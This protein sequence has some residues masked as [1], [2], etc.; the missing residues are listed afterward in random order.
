MEKTKSF[1]LL[2]WTK[3]PNTPMFLTLEGL[4]R[5]LEKNLGLKSVGFIMRDNNYANLKPDMDTDNYPYGYF[6]LTNFT[7]LVDRQANK[8]L[9]RHGSG[10]DLSNYSNATIDKDYTF[11]VELTFEFHFVTNNVVDMLNISE[12][13]AVISAID[14][15]SFEIFI[16]EVTNWMVSVNLDGGSTSVPKAAQQDPANPA[17]FDVPFS[18]SV[19]TRV[20]VLKSVP[21]INNEG[22]ISASVS[23]KDKQEKPV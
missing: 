21:K 11:P 18:L 20:G 10:I 6:S 4:K 14:K 1:D 19:K 8:T 7:I 15:F 16:S 12:K 3:N 22:R 9:A 17:A 2:D 5:T 13:M 23:V